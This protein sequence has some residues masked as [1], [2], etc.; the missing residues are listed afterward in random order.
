MAFSPNEFLSNVRAKDGLAKPSRFEVILPIPPYINQFI[1]NSLLEKI[2]NF[3]NS[4]ISDVSGLINSALGKRET[5]SGYSATSNSTMTR[6]LALQ[7]ESAELPGKTLQTADVKIYGPTF[8]VPYNTQ[9]AD[10]TLSFLCTNQFYERKLF[11]RWM[12]AIQPTDTNNMRFPK[13]ANSRYMTNVKIV[14]YDDFIKQIYAVELLDAFP[15]GIASQALSWSEDGF[16]R[17]SIQFAY[18]KYR[19]IY[20]G[21]YDI[22][23][24][25]GSLLGAGASRLLPIGSAL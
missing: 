17:L 24:A 21:S 3:P 19:T 11:D 20:E 10:T 14:Q 1:G 9:Y 16:H 8:K 18:Q 4:I 7:C 12:E 22:G 15:I 25:I 13:G 2:L 5:Q 6:Y 23:A